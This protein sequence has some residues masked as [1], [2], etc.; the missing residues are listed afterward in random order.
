MDGVLISANASQETFSSN[1][2][3]VENQ[4]FLN[5]YHVQPVGSSWDDIASVHQVMGL[6]PRS[7]RIWFEIA[8][9]IHDDD[10]AMLTR[11][12][13]HLPSAA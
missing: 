6:T 8:I 11:R 5:A 4:A 13:H 10:F 12:K 1:G 7:Y 3:D 2:L 9:P